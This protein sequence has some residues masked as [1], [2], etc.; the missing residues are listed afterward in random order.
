VGTATFGGFP[1]IQ[2]GFGVPAAPQPANVFQ[3][4]ALYILAGLALLYVINAVLIRR[5]RRQA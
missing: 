1:N 5:S 4:N 3:Q 2:R